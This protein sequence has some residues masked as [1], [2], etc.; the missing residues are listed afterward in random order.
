MVGPITRSK[1]L[2]SGSSFFLLRRASLKAPDDDRSAAVETQRPAWQRVELFGV[3]H[4]VTRE[5]LRSL[6]GLTAPDPFANRILSPARNVI[7]LVGGRA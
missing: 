3:T 5:R 4:S 6:A 1:R 2:A 7:A